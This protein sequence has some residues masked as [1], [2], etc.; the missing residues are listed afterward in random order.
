MLKDIHIDLESMKGDKLNESS[1]IKMAAQLK[2]LL[3]HLMGPIDYNMGRNVRVTGSKSDLK[4]FQNA[5]SKEKKYMDAY[6]KHGLNDP[7]VLNNRM[8]LDKA[9]YKFEKETGIKWPLK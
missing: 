8:K 9:V 7:R 4:A 1:V 3:Y 2:Y 5:I 6:L